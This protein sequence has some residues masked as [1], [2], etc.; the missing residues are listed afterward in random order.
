M[1][2]L[3]WKVELG[4]ILEDELMLKLKMDKNVLKQEVLVRKCV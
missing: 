1:N 4:V 3:I 2:V